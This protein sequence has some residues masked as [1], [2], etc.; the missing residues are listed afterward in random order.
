MDFL[1]KFIESP[2]KCVQEVQ[3]YFWAHTLLKSGTSK[4]FH[5]K[6]FYMPNVLPEIVNWMEAAEGKAGG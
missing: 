1:R 6:V 5:A 2:W 4:V 3:R